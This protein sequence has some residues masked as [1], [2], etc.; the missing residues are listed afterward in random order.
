MGKEQASHRFGPGQWVTRRDTGEHVRVELW[1]AIAA[2]YRVRSSKG[3]LQL[4]G[5]ADLEQVCEHPEAGLGRHWSRCLAAGCGAPL[6]PEL[7]TCSLCGA[8]RC[9]CGRCRCVRTPARSKTAP[10]KAVRA[11]MLRAK[12]AATDR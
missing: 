10:P 4:L 8:P 1:S 11:K 9:T 3:G 7:T 6:T 12:P 5:E 2:A